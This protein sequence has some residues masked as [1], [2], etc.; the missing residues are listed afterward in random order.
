MTK[1][2]S[3]GGTG[4]TAQFSDG[5]W[6]TYNPRRTSGSDGWNVYSRYILEVPLV[7]KLI[8]TVMIVCD[9]PFNHIRKTGN[10]S[11]GGSDTAI[12][13]PG[14]VGITATDVYSYNGNPRVWRANGE[15]GAGLY[16]GR[17]GARYMYVQTGLKF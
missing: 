9:Q 6:T 8:W 4:G 5:V 13:P 15:P 14:I 3:I 12:I 1:T 7:N 16:T 2:G 17:A 11:P 10:F